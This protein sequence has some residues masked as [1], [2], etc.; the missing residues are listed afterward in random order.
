MAMASRADEVDAHDTTQLLVMRHGE[1]EWNAEQRMQGQLDIA[2]NSAGRQQAEAIAQAL[3]SSGMAE[4]IDAV[5]S[6]D[7]ARAKVTADII[8]KACVNARRFE[9]SGLREFNLGDFQG[10]LI[11]DVAA[12]KTKVADA[13]CSGNF[14]N[15]YPGENGESVQEVI[16]RGMAS[17]RSAAKLGRCVLV[18]SHGGLIKWCAVHIEM[19]GQLP[20]QAMQQERVGVVLRAPLRNCCCSTLSYDHSRDSFASESWFQNL[21]SKEARDDIEN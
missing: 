3:S 2:L 18:V 4:R 20:Q 14:S 17:L 9:D 6:S 15:R 1:T 12:E 11:S 21:C 7:L 16:D 19:A 5:V 10:K 8:A 13:W